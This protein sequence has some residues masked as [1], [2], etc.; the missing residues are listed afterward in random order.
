MSRIFTTWRQSSRCMQKSGVERECRPQASHVT[1]SHSRHVENA[2]ELVQWMSIDWNAPLNEDCGWPGNLPPCL[3]CGTPCVSGGRCTTG[4]RAPSR[5]EAAQGSDTCSAPRR[6]TERGQR[7]V[8]APV[9]GSPTFWY[10]LNTRDVKYFVS[11]VSL[12]VG[13]ESKQTRCYLGRWIVRVLAPVALLTDRMTRTE[14]NCCNTQWH[15]P[16]QE[17]TRNRC[18]WFNPSVWKITISSIVVFFSSC[19]FDVI[20]NTFSKRLSHPNS[21]F[22]QSVSSVAF[23][24]TVLNL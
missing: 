24:N 23:V 7:W 4:A 2:R 9:Q 10:N 5:V 17:R 1:G 3:Q 22:V 8:S 15:A 12:E 21:A 16:K 11:A 13:F 20:K 18:L 14:I 6:A 19:W